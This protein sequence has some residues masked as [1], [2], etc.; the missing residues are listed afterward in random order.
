M[1]RHY[2]TVVKKI[3]AERGIGRDAALKIYKTGLNGVGVAKSR[4][5]EKV[6][7]GRKGA[8]GKKSKKAA[9][10]E[11]LTCEG[12]QLAIRQR[13]DFLSATVAGIRQQL[14]AYQEELG[15]LV[16]ASDALGMEDVGTSFAVNVPRS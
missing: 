9:E 8:W 4:K 10:P 3:M 11:K 12:I 2:M 15:Q 7:K 16:K 5:G 13:V 1:A 6:G 14:D